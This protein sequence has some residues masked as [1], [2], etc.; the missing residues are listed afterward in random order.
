[1][2]SRVDENIQRVHDLVMSDHRIIIR[3]IAAQLGIS[4]R[5]LYHDNALSH[6]TFIA[7]IYQKQYYYW[8][9]SS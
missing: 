3:M 4:Q 6:T 9:K 1:M 8:C 2:M 7:R 5:I